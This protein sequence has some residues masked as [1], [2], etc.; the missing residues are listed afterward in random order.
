MDPTKLPSNPPSAPPPPAVGANPGPA[1]PKQHNGFSLAER[2]IILAILYS[3]GLMAA[4][5]LAF[6]FRF[7]FK[8]PENF[9]ESFRHAWWM[10]LPLKLLA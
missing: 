9:Q 1:V 7:D 8:V 5:W 2:R 4:Y 10:T 3:A 6:Q